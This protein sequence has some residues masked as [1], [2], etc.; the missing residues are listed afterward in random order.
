MTAIYSPEIADGICG[1]LA[2]GMT[3]GKAL[4]PTSLLPYEYYQWRREIP[5]FAKQ[6]EN[7]RMEAAHAYLDSALEIA[8][9]V[10]EDR[11]A[12][13]KAELKVKTRQWMAAVLNP[14][15][16]GQKVEHSGEM[17]HKYVAQPIPVEQRNSDRAVARPN[18]AAANGHS[19]G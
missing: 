16:Y 14:Q 19:A 17:T 11:D 18:G 9:E 13:R 2:A 10:V 6:T 1:R 3:L 7:A 15:R 12:I 4:A 8:D 5:E